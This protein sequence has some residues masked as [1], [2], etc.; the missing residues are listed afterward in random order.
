MSEEPQVS[1]L[2]KY[3]AIPFGGFA[4]LCFFVMRG[5]YAYDSSVLLGRGS[6]TVNVSGLPKCS[7]D[8]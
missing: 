7:R 3:I 6:H 5:L 2:V 4:I 1:P 8:L